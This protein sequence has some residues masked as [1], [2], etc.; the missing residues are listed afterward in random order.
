MKYFRLIAAG[1]LLL[2]FFS[3]S[4]QAGAQCSVCRASAESN[5]NKK[6]NRVGAGLNSGILYLMAV[7]YMMGGIAFLIWYKQRKKIA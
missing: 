1:I 5:I 2:L 4:F 3:S 6:E 7:P